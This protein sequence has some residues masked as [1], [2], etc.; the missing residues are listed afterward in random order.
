MLATIIICVH[1]QYKASL[2]A[3]SWIFRKKSI[4]GFKTTLISHK[5]FRKTSE[6]HKHIRKIIKIRVDHKSLLFQGE[7]YNE[8]DQQIKKETLYKKDRKK[9]EEIIHSLITFKC[10]SDLVSKYWSF[11]SEAHPTMERT[12]SQWKH[13]SSS[14]LSNTNN[15]DQSWKTTFHNQTSERQLQ[16]P[17][18]SVPTKYLWWRTS[19]SK[20]V[21]HISLSTNTQER[22]PTKA[23]E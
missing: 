23:L 16:F 5:W 10:P 19:G 1:D 13:L 20:N 11:L 22:K 9:G 4:L 7:F 3:M 17:V 15:V 18:P 8:D 21:N 6:N 12:T 14:S 2:V